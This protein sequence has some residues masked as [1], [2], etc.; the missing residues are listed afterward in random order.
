MPIV[1]G[2]AFGMD[3]AASRGDPQSAL[4]A[5]QPYAAGAG[6]DAGVTRASLLQL[7]AAAAGRGHDFSPDAIAVDAPAAGLGVKHPFDAVDGQTTGAGADA[8]FGADILD[9]HAARAGLGD[10]RELHAVDSD[11]A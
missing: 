7:Y 5:A 2:F 10:K 4:D 3:A 6:F 11:A 1:R 9:R 8:T